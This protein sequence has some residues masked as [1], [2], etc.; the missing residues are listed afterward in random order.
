MGFGFHVDLNVDV[1]IDV[2]SSQFTLKFIV[3]RDVDTIANSLS[4]C[5]LSIFFI[6]D[7]T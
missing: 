1:D 5:I 7:A 3:M 6:P 4:S 2:S